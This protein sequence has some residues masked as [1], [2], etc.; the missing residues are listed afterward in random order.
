MLPELFVLSRRKKPFNPFYV[1]LI[2]AGIVF[3][4]TA[5]AY[6]V[7]M[8]QMLKLDQIEQQ[9][10]AET[11]LLGFLSAQGDRLMLIELGVLAVTTFAAIGTDEFWSRRA[12]AEN[13]R[14]VE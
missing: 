9:V 4:V 10:A 6:G 3:A 13:A 2:L 7:M 12:A 11:G 5:C 1:L 8:V 14:P